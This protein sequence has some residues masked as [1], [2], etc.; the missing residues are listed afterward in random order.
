MVDL[1]I[2]YT[3]QVVEEFLQL[4]KVK[5]NKD[6]PTTKVYIS[7]ANPY[8]NWLQKLYNFYNNTNLIKEQK[9]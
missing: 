7:T 2:Y 3:N 8:N 1:D 5:L 4:L 6:Y 9:E